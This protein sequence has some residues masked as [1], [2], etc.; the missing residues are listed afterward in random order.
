MTIGIEEPKLRVSWAE[1]MEFLA[2]F[3]VGSGLYENKAPILDY[4]VTGCI[5]TISWTP[6]TGVT[7]I[8]S[9]INELFKT[10]APLR[11]NSS[12]L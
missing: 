8:P 5:I 2:V 3:P 7:S 4:S 10:N 12:A 6:L 9:S 11:L 1:H